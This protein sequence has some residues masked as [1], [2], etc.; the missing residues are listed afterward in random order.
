MLFYV[1]VFVIEEW[2]SGQAFAFSKGQFRLQWRSAPVGQK[3]QPQDKL[4]WG[5]GWYDKIMGNH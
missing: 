3:F 4:I 2:A 1:L 5:K